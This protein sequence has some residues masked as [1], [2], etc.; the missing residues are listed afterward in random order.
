MSFVRE[1]SVALFAMWLLN[2]Q[3]ADTRTHCVPIFFNEEANITKSGLQKIPKYRCHSSRVGLA[4]YFWFTGISNAELV[5]T[6]APCI[7]NSRI[8]YAPVIWKPASPHWGL[9]GALTFYASESEWSLRSP[10]GDNSEWC[11]TPVPA[12]PHTRGTPF[13]KQLIIAKHNTRVKRHC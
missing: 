6:Y 7:S 11:L 1:A 3:I 12:V 10:A 5:A 9:R 4:A 2:F 8:S 13:V